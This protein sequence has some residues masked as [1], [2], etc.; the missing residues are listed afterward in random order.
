MVVPEVG[1]A[2]VTLMGAKYWNCS[3]AGARYPPIDTPT[4][5]VATS[6]KALG[7]GEEE[8]GKGGINKGV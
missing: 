5:T 1:V 7:G 4:D 2:A 8:G 6:I 3:E